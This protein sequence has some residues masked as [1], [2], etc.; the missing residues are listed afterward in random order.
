MI[1]R[2]WFIREYDRIVAEQSDQGM[3]VEKMRDALSHRYADAVERGESRY[4][5][6]IVDEGRALTNRFVSPVRDA[7][8]MSFRKNVGDI[9]D[10]LNGDTILG[11]DDPRLD[12]AFPIGDGTDKT[13]RYWSADD[14]TDATTE[15]YRNAASA[16]AS[17][18]EFDE[19]SQVIVG[20]LR[21]RN[22][23]LTGELF[24]GGAS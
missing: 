8:R 22:V 11:R 19:L 21:S 6:D 3:T 2:E 13:L 5:D 23:R 1:D 15:R 12:Q 14:W 4:V 9:I 20:A 17:A 16:T 24:P 18:A 10:A 7:R